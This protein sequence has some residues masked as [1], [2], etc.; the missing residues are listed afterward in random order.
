[1]RDGRRV[2]VTGGAGFI[3]LNLIA[4]LLATDPDL[5]VVSVDILKYGWQQ[6]SL[7]R[8]AFPSRHTFVQADI[9]NQGAM[10]QILK[11]HHINLVFH[12]AAETHVDRSIHS[13]EEFVQTNVVGTLRI[14]EAFR[15]VYGERREE[16][17]FCH[18]STDEVFGTLGQDAPAFDEET[19][20]APRS[21]YAASKAGAD[22]LARAYQVTY[23]LPILVT[24]CSNN[25]GPFQYPE[26]LI[27]LMIF[28]ALAGKPLP[29]YGDGK[30]KRDWLHVGDHCAGLWLAATRGLPGE[31]HLF[32]GGEETENLTL[33]GMLCRLLDEM[34]PRDDGG[35]YAG[36][37]YHVADRPGHDRRYAVDSS[38]AR[39]DLGWAPQMGL[40]EGLRETVGW[41]LNAG[42]WLVAIAA[43]G[44]FQDWLATNYGGREATA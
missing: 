2:L 28:N 29:V 9:L 17:R 6:A 23:D 43:D 40:E 15:S 36:L 1:M 26:K 44:G 33:V 31:T 3:G 34:R 18:V 4:Y 11:D 13:P 7:A 12:L 22:H 8:A 39:R 25:Y 41:Y 42:D 16:M 14:L 10:T 20:Y 5:S 30:Q 21:P 19:C 38:K 32:G 35:S 24:N 27:P 37:I